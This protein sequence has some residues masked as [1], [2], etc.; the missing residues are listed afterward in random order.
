MTPIAVSIE[1]GAEMIDTSPST[2]RAYI[3]QGVIPVVK[4]PSAK[5]AHEQ[6]R[7]VLIAVADLE[8][9]VLKHRVAESAR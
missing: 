4:L 1:V 7:R 8:A 3:D 9:F 5:H 6:S 2:L